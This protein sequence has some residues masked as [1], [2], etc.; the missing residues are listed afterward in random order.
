MTKQAELDVATQELHRLTRA[1]NDIGRELDTHR[2]DMPLATRGRIARRARERW[3]NKY[4]KLKSRQ[5]Q[6]MTEGYQA[7]Q[8]VVQ[9]IAEVKQL[10]R[11]R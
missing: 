3:M 10:E 11:S 2:A 5:R 9:L 8:R 7:R 6:L 4:E 1:I